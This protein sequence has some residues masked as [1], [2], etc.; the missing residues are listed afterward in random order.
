M[1]NILQS[2]NNSFKYSIKIDMIFVLFNAAVKLSGIF[3]RIFNEMYNLRGLK[4]P[5][6]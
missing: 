3:N 5:G 2:K 6:F 1:Y 4:Q